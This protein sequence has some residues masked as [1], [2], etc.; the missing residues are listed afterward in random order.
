MNNNT[1]IFDDIETVSKNLL[2]VFER[3]KEVPGMYD[4]ICDKKKSICRAIPEQIRSGVVKIAVVGSIKSG[5]S[6][7]INSFL[8]EDLLKRGAGVVTSIITKVR[9]GD[10][11]KAAILLKSWDEIN[12]EIEKAL[13]FFPDFENRFIEIDE[14]GF[15]LRRKN[16]R[17]LLK[18]VN[19]Q[20]RSDLSVTKKGIRPESIILANAMEGYEFVKDVVQADASTIEFTNKRFQEHKKFTGTDSF[21]FFV[22]DV[23][24]SVETKGLDPQIE[25]ADCQGSD[26]TN[27]LHMAQI[28]DYLVSASL[29]IYL[30][31]SR[32][33]LREADIRFLTIIQKMGLMDNILFVVN[34]D[35]SE[36]ESLEDLINVEK[37]IKNELAYFKS[38]IELFTFSSLYNLFCKSKQDLSIKNLKRLNQWKEDFD[39]VNYSDTMKSDF[40]S[41]LAALLK[42]KR[43]MLLV[44]NHIEHIRIIANDAEKRAEI[45][46]ELLNENVSKAGLAVENLEDMHKRA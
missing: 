35:F 29:I 33:G 36:H 15:D 21:A 44:A 45:F 8:N 12:Q 26:S 37:T 9:K 13:L 7:F 31:S 3:M 24:L 27:P 40:D 20:L 25:I 39:F 30:I 42:K 43:F 2:S 34:S 17:K 16:D 46:N 22:K 38:D 28:E 4:D 18:K 5:K 19:E 23:S 6:T 32:T 14:K 10:I 1:K 41:T 11:S